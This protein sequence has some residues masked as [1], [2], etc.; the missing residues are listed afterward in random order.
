MISLERAVPVNPSGTVSQISRA[1]VWR[2]LVLKADNALPFVP[3]M[4]YCKVLERESPHRFVR[5]IE[6]KG[7][8]MRERVT[9]EPERQVTF[10]RLSGPVRGT[11]RNFIDEK[12]D[13]TLWLRFAFALELEGATAGSRAEKDYAASMEKAYLGAVD[14]TLGA[15]RRLH[16]ETTGAMHAPKWLRDDYGDVAAQRMDDF[17]AHHT[18]DARVFFGNNPPCVGKEQ[19]QQAIGGLWR[20]IDGLSHRFVHVWLQGDTAILEAAITCRRKDGGRVTVPCVSIL[21]RR[22]GK[23]SELR[24]HMD[25]APVFAA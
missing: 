24:V 12:A 20:T 7:D 3:Q 16:D 11:I 5:E 17:L 23:V 9:L 25:L 10:E 19:I 14:A 6:F 1:D 22:D 2:G 15:I 13:G 8:R 18:H 21:E 4:T